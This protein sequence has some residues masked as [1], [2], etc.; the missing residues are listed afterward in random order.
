MEIKLL[1]LRKRE[2]TIRKLGNAFYLLNQVWFDLVILIE[3]FGSHQN[4]A[5]MAIGCSPRQ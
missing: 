1:H 4:I 2:T 3:P 5:T